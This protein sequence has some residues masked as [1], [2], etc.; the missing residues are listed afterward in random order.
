MG[1]WR[2]KIFNHYKFSDK[3]QT[4]GGTLSTLMGAG[5]LV[6]ILYGVFV[7]F[8]A[9]GEGGVVVGAL[10]LLS[11]ILSLIGLIIGLLSFK[12][13]DKFY[14]LSRIGSLLCGILLVL[15]AAVFLMGMG[16]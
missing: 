1:N 7:S 15:M 5:S 10:G 12:E 2:M 3:S 13:K 9:D 8:R 11:L 4:L 6:C 16:I 14:V